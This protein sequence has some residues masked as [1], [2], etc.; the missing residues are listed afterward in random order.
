MQKSIQSGFIERTIVAINH[1]LEQSLFAEK[2][3]RQ[4]GLLQ[5]FDPRLKLLATLML[6]I[7]AGSSRQLFVIVSFFLGTL[8]AAS[9]SKVKLGSFIQ[10]VCLMVLL[11]TGVIALP[12]LFLTPGPALWVLP[13]AITITC[14]GAMT[15]LFLIARV[16]TSVSMATLFILT[17]PWNDVLKAFGVLH[18]PDVIVL[19]LSMTYRYI[20]LL[21]HEAND[22]FLSRKSRLIRRLTREEENTLLGA[23]A[24]VLLDKSL[25]LSSEVYLAMQSRGYHHY[26]RTLNDFSMRWWDWLAGCA[27]V[28]IMLIVIFCGQ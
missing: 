18:V 5:R 7:A 23:T 13:F 6:L 1:T 15:A 2:I 17:T 20:H 21:L 9:L 4:R 27:A 12:A 22:M 26:P 28:S 19:I 16:T 24:G 10:R 25:L 8:M 3:A 14:T 11:F